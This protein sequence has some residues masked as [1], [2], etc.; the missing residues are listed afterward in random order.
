MAGS[1]GFLPADSLWGTMALEIR[2]DLDAPL[3]QLCLMTHPNPWQQ[4]I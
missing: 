3:T 1:T 2:L 4:Q